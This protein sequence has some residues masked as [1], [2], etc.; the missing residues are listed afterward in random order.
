MSPRKTLAGD[1]LNGRKPAAAP[2]SAAASRAANGSQPARRTPAPGHDGLQGGQAVDPVEEVVEVHHRHDPQDRG[3]RGQ[4]AQ[5]VLQQRRHRD[6]LEPSHLEHDE[7]HHAELGDEAREGRQ[8]GPIV[9]QPDERQGDATHHDRDGAPVVG[10]AD[11]ESHS[12]TSTAS[13]DRGPAASGDD[14]PVRGALVGAIQQADLPGQARE[15][16][17]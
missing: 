4:R 9:G 1:Q 10:P 3:R 8:A 12:A 6:A 16:P 15:T 17:A 14:R 13:G 7:A 5:V 11:P 2:T